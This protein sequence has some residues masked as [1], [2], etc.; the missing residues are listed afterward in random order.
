[1]FGDVA[2]NLLRLMGHSG[3]VPSAIKSEDIPE[4]PENFRKGIVDEAAL[5]QSD[6]EFAPQVQ[7]ENEEPAISLRTRALPLIERLE[8]SEQEEEEIGKDF[9]RRERAF[10]AFRRSLSIPGEVDESKVEASFKRGV[11]TIDLP[12]SEEAQ[13]KNQAHRCQG[14]IGIADG[15]A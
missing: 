5:K 4:A 1:M 13:K 14:E 9:Y 2:V 11:L 7:G 3:T 15:L 12:K 10:G 8:A 6:S